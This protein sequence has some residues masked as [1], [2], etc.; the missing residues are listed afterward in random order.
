MVCLMFIRLEFLRWLWFYFVVGLGVLI[1]PQA[2]LPAQNA[3][4]ILEKGDYTARGRL[5]LNRERE[6][7]VGATVRLFQVRGVL[8]EAREVATTT[9]VEEGRYVFTRLSVPRETQVDYLKYVVVISKPGHATSFSTVF[10]PTDD[11]P[12]MFQPGVCSFTGRVVDSVGKPI[13]G[14][15]VQKYRWGASKNVPS[16][17]FKTKDD[18]TFFEAPHRYF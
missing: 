17:G 12:S 11:V 14:A 8:R 3:S 4:T 16:R 15:S 1:S 5:I 13:S 9:S 10:N 7:A 6:P 18:G 2:T